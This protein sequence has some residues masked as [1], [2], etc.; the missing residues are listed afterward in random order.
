VKGGETPVGEIRRLCLDIE[1]A[2]AGKRLTEKLVNKQIAFKL[3]MDFSA[4]GFGL[5][6]K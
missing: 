4:Y 1:T 3:L 2:P 6:E 5:S